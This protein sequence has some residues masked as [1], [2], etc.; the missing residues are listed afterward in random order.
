MPERSGRLSVGVGRKH[1]MALRKASLRTLS[2]RRVYAL[3][4]QAGAQ[5]LAVEW[6]RDKAAVRNVLA[7]VSHPKPASRFR[8]ETRVDNFLRIASR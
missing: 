5:Y 2:I 4:C 6:I 7:P 8:R 1:S 3:R